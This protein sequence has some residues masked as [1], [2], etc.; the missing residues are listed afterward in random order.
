MEMRHGGRNYRCALISCSCV[1]SS[2]NQ[3][4][5]TFGLVGVG[6]IVSLSPRDSVVSKLQGE[7]RELK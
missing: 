4:Y 5:I 1:K 3:K 2:L 7:R 6:S